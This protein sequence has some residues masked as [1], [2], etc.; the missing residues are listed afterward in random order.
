MRIVIVGTWEGDEIATEKVLCF[1]FNVGTEGEVV[2]FAPMT[3]IAEG[4]GLGKEEED[5][6]LWSARESD[7]ATESACPSP[8]QLKPSSKEKGEGAERSNRST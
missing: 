7:C 1:K 6:A 5:G 4:G 2:L 3:W 8:S